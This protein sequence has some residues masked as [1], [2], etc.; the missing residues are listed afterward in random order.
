MG[1][2]Q[3]KKIQSLIIFIIVLVAILWI[4]QDNY[5]NIPFINQSTNETEITEDQNQERSYLEKIDNFIIKE[6]SNDQVLLHIIEADVY[7]S[8]KNSPV[9]LETVKATTFDEFQNET[10]TLNSNRAV[11][12]KS[13]TIHFI[14]EV[15]IK[16]VSGV[17]HEI[18]AEL[19]VVKDGQISSN[20]KIVYLGESAKINSQSMEMNIDKDIMNLNGDVEILQDN[21]AIVDTMD[22]FISHADGAKKYMSEKATVYRSNQNI[23]NSD[24]GIDIDMNSKLTRLIGSTEILIG[25]GSSLKSNDMIIDQSNGGEIFMSN[26]PSHFQSNT[27]DIKAKKMH[28]DA[29][30]KKLKLTD[31]VV[32]TY[33]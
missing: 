9:Q 3:T 13:G 26:S 2:F 10:V 29:I 24:K 23:V 4:F 27:V 30:S 20:R 21:G 14:G 11:M 28:Y 18:D 33:E 25:S 22:L 8:F 19:L 17:L 15:E 5:L 31:E 1:L 16:T 12:F 32:A 7:K 6:Y